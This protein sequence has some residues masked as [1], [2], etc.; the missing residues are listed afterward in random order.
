MQMVEWDLEKCPQSH[1]PEALQKTMKVSLSDSNAFHLLRKMLT[2]V[3]MYHNYLSKSG[4]NLTL[5]PLSKLNQPVLDEA[6]SIL[7]KASK[8]ITVIEEGE[9]LWLWISVNVL[10]RKKLVVECN[11]DLILDSYDKIA[12]MDMAM[13]HSDSV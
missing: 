8:L 7:L 3:N 12:G 1:L 11:L 4:L 9:Q 6:L 10:E 5:F 13:L 2:S